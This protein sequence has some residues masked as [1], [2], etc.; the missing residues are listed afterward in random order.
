MIYV[1]GFE[2]GFADSASSFLE[3]EDPIYVFFCIISRYVFESG[4]SFVGLKSGILY[5]IGVSGW[6][7]GPSER[8]G[9]KSFLDARLTPPLVLPFFNSLFIL[10]VIFAMT[11]CFFLFTVGCRVVFFPPGNEGLF[12]VCPVFLTSLAAAWFAKGISLRPHPAQEIK[13][14][15]RFFNATSFANFMIGTLAFFWHGGYVSQH[16]QQCQAGRRG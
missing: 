6:G 15:E 12:V 5:G 2:F 16:C 4:F 14:R 11:L 7:F 1:L 10:F 8:L 9:A 13:F 3:R